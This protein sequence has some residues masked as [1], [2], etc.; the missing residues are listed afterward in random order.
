MLGGHSNATDYKN[1]LKLVSQFSLLSPWV[2][3]TWSSRTPQVYAGKCRVKEAQLQ[4]E[5]ESLGRP[6]KCALP[7]LTLGV[8]DFEVWGWD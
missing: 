8:S 5:S 1:F 2:Q 3:L 6:V 4:H 7:G